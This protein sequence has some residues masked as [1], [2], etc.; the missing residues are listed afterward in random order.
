MKSKFACLAGGLTALALL[1]SVLQ[2]Q[3]K[4]DKNVALRVPHTTKPLSVDCSDTSAI[5][6][7]VP[8]VKLSKMALQDVPADAKMPPVLDANKPIAAIFLMSDPNKT[9]SKLPTAVKSKLDSFDAQY[10][11]QW[12]ESKL[13]GYVEVKENDVD[14]GHPGISQKE[15]RR[16]PFGAAFSN[17]F[18]SSVVV[19]VGAPSWRWF[20][21]EMHVHVRSPNAKPVKSM[22]FGRTNDEEDFRKLAGEAIAC[23]ARGGWI[24]KF[25]VAWLP[26]DDWLP[27]Q[28]VTANFRLLAPLAYEH[29]GYVLASVV[30]F[31]L[32]D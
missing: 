26:F 28:G 10:A 30:P 8:R 6:E 32:S 15:F 11:F 4:T 12:D 14:A 24:A 9:V 3:D 27:K 17:F 1:V 25:V 5:W 7:N 19:Q 31:V 20:V 13:Y 22:L 21:T 29:E 16:S 2:A 23:P 18:F